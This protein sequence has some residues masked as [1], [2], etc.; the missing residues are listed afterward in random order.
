MAAPTKKRIIEMADDE[1]R[2]LM[3]LVGGSDS[4]ELK[5]TV[6]E[7]HHRSTI[8]GLGMDA[9]QAQIRQVYFFDTPDL[10][11]NRQGVVVRARRVQGRGDDT[12]VKL[13]PVVP[14]QLP[15]EFRRAPGMVVEVD[16]MPGGWVCSASCKGSLGTTD[17]T[18]VASG[19]RPIRK[20]FSKGQRAFY[21]S[22]VSDDIALD[23]LSILG[24]IFVLKLNFRP[25]GYDRKMVAEAW[26]YP[27]GSRI[28]ELSTKCPPADM[29]SVAV[30]SRLFLSE[31][32]VD[33]S[34][35]Q[36]TKTRTALEY[37]CQHVAQ[38]AET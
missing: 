25:E 5:L 15:D 1:L 16:A 13:R 4:V 14:D 37:F 11:L 26:L 29:L 28:L 24:P 20:L 6:P 38:P 23:D 9:L 7:E 10:A 33:L 19:N 32:G 3:D 18:S 17:V 12:V 36:Q 21:E 35:E 31:R 22:H 30:A 2:Q 27:D 8:A 34:G